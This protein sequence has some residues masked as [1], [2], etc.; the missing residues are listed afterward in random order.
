M[1]KMY[2]DDIVIESLFEHYGIWYK[3]EE[4]RVGGLISDDL[5]FIA[6]RDLKMSVIEAKKYTKLYLKCDG[7]WYGYYRDKFGSKLR[8]R[9]CRRNTINRIMVGL[10]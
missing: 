3:G 7:K 4:V 2:I 9:L 1:L 8:L 10:V 5:K 6:N